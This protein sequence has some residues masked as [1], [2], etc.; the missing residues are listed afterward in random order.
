MFAVD[1]RRFVSFATAARFG[2]PGDSARALSRARHEL[3]RVRAGLRHELGLVGRLRGAVSLR[4]LA[5]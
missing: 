3:R 2:P 5:L 4:S 1:A